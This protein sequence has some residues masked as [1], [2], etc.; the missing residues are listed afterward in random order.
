[1]T[2]DTEYLDGAVRQ[3]AR[4]LSELGLDDGG[5][6]A[7]MMV[8]DWSR[9]QDMRVQIT[10]DGHALREGQVDMVAADGSVLWLARDGVFERQL[11]LR[12]DGVEAWIRLGSPQAYWVMGGHMT[13]D[14]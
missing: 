8:Q 2:E 12:S 9:L 6:H 14:E 11:V 3:K 4:P 5:T 1:M 13:V 7:S 10:E